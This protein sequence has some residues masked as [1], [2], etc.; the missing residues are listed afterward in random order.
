MAL[1]GKEK[2]GQ[3]K[4]KISKKREAADKKFGFGGKKKGKKRNTK[5]SRRAVSLC[6][7]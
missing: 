4:K 6:C 7:V 5:E 3:V 2:D 1:R